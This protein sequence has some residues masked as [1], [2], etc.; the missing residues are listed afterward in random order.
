MD[1]ERYR[2]QFEGVHHTE[3]D[4]AVLFLAMAQA[5]DFE[6]LGLI[7][8]VNKVRENYREIYKHSDKIPAIPAKYIKAIDLIG[9]F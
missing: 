9:R 1:K 7:P 6:K 8:Y 3:V 2:C 5:K 4:Y